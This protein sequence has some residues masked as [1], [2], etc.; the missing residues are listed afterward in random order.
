MSPQSEENDRPK[1]VGPSK[2]KLR[3]LKKTAASNNVCSID[4]NKDKGVETGTKCDGNINNY[5]K[6]APEVGA[7]R[8]STR[9]GE[10]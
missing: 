5:A 3:Y 7:G 4:A 10:D 8:R 2:G 6:D 9:K 1:A